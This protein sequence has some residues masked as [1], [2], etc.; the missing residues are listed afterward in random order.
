MRHI[1][2]LQW[3]GSAQADFEELVNMEDELERSLSVDASV[4]GHDFGSGEMNIFIGTDQPPQTFADVQR[5]LSHWPRWTDVRAAHR[6]QSGD[7]YTV[8]WP[9]G[10]TDF[11]VI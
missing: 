10:E 8:L 6:E 2:V 9:V 7:T 1:L 5:V 4:D 3:P 11:R